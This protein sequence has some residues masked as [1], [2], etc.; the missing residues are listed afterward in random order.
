MW[1][2]E[3]K[4]ILFEYVVT[5]KL[6]LSGF[7]PCCQIG[8]SSMKESGSVMTLSMRSLRSERMSM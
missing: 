6:P 2:I 8:T 5:C 3:F 1:K 7:D 4:R